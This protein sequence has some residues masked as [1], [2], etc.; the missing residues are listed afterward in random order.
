MRARLISRH[1]Q[2]ADP[3]STSRV[4]HHSVSCNERLL[5]RLLQRLLWR[6]LSRLLWRLLQR[7]LSRLLWRLLPRLLLRLPPRLLWRLLSRLLQRLL[8]RLLSRLFLFIT[9]SPAMRGRGVRHLD[10]ALCSMS[11]SDC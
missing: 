11:A 5:P 6:L 4:I 7:L 1:D 8:W 10:T 3:A 9:L 2:G